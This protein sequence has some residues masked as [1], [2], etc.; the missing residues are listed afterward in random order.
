MLFLSRGGYLLEEKNSPKGNDSS[1][2]NQQ[3]K[4]STYFV[5]FSSK[6]SLYFQGQASPM[7]QPEIIN[8]FQAFKHVMIAATLIKKLA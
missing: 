2:E 4:S 7:Q 1:P 5:L 8:P 3:E 6:R